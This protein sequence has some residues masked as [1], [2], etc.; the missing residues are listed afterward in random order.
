MATFS[1]TNNNSGS[2]YFTYE[3][4]RNDNGFYDVTSLKAA[5]G[6]FSSVTENTIIQSDY[7]WSV[8]VPSGASSLVF[9]PAV[10]VP[11]GSVNYAITGNSTYTIT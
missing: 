2:V 4:T 6:S 7:I 1:F 10:T 9:T 8:V 11:G 3:T 5:S